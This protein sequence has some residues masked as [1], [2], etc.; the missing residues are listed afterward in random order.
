[1]RISGFGL[2]CM[3]ALFALTVS[4]GRA[5]SCSTSCST[6]GSTTTCTS[7]DT[8][9]APDEGGNG[10]LY[11]ANTYPSCITVPSSVTGT[12]SSAAGSVQVQLTNVVSTAPAI[13]FSVQVMRRD[14]ARQ[15]RLAR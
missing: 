1:M 6:S 5:N 3:G 2:L 12:V 14:H 4:T 7:T 15:R 8:I 11:V 10:N 13:I 9:K